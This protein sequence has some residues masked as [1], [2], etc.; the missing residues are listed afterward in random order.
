[1]A[2]SPDGQFLLAGGTDGAA[3]IHRVSDGES[4]FNQ[5]DF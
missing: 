2:W 1:M 5:E 4:R 3:R